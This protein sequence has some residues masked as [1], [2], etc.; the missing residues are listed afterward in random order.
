MVRD[1]AEQADILEAIQER[2]VDKFPEFNLDSNCFVSDVPE[3]MVVP[4]SDVW[5]VIAPGDGN[6]D[7]GYQVGGGHEQVTEDATV[8]VAIGAQYA[9]DESG[10]LQRALLGRERGT[11]REYK[12]EFLRILLKEWEPERANQQLLR[13]SMLYVVHASRPYLQ[14]TEA[15]I[16]WVRMELIFQTMFD[17]EL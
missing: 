12:R 10:K 3:P 6:F 16:T 8:I 1:Y 5:C 2:I 4:P 15:G 14:K 17:W 9:I 13:N 11:I 7:E